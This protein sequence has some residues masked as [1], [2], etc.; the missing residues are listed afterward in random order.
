MG[1]MLATGAKQAQK[2][3]LTCRHGAKLVFVREDNT[4][5]IQNQLVTFA[6]NVKKGES[7]PKGGA[8]FVAIVGDGSAQFLEGVDDRLNKLDADYT[9]VVVG[10]A[11]YS[12]GEDELMGP[13]AWRDRP[14][15]AKGGVIA[16]VLRDGDWNIA[17]TWM[18]DNKIAANPWPPE[19]FLSRSAASPGTKSRPMRAT[20]PGIRTTCPCSS[21]VS[22]SASPSITAGSP[23][24]RAPSRC[25][26]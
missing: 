10:S 18:G 22:C 3:S 17:L 12:R 24:S 19:T 26:G 8:H 7:N 21:A 9:A 15:R 13:Q 25:S 14:Q 1:M 20:P 4:D 11:G 2:D 16:G 23:S 5:Q 6:K